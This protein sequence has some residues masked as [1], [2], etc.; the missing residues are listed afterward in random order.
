MG[1]QRENRE[2]FEVVCSVNTCNRRSSFGKSLDNSNAQ[3]D[4]H[5]PEFA[6][7]QRPDLL[8]ALKKGDNLV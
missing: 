4:R 5:G 8:V 7:R 3:H 6:Y 2:H 1:S